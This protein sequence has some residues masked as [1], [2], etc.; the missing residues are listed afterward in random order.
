MKAILQL[1]HIRN[2]SPAGGLT[3]DHQSRFYNVMS[4]VS[5]IRNI[6]LQNVENYTQLTK[7]EFGNKS[8][9][10]TEITVENWVSRVSTSSMYTLADVWAQVIYF[11]A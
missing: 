9:N 8:E 7:A 5:F 11:D 3:A 1:S 10:N 6:K 2:P 4:V